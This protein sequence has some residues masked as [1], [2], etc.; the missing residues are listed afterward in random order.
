MLVEHLV[1]ALRP[2]DESDLTALP[3]NPL[4]HQVWPDGDWTIWA[5]IA[6]RGAGKTHTGAYHVHRRAAMGHSRRIALVAPTA[7][8]GRDVM[9]EGV[10]GILSIAS[11]AT[12]PKYE[13][14]KRRLTWPNGAIATLYSAEDPDQLRGPQHDLAWAEEPASWADARK[15]MVAQNT[16]WS[17]LMFG[18]RIR[19]RGSFAGPPRVIVT[20]TP[21]P[22][23]LILDIMER[24]RSERG[25]LTRGTTYDNAANLDTTFFEDLIIMYKGT[26]VGRQE[27]NAELLLDVPGALWT[28][29]MIDNTRVLLEQVPDLVTVV[30]AIDPSITAGPTSDEAGIVIAGLGV[31]GRGYVLG[32]RSAVMSPDAWGRRALGALDEY[33][34][35]YIVGEANQG[36]DMVESI[37]RLVAQQSGRTAPKVKL[38]HA[39]R[40]KQTRAQPVASLY[41]QGRISHV[42]ALSLLE[43]QLTTWTPEDGDSPDRLDALVWALTD[44]MV[45]QRSDATLI[46]W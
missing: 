31:D 6:G 18:L 21:R 30:V 46:R 7:A 35:D 12:R 13:P 9:V 11:N 39:S 22:L 29:A 4:P 19:R 41:E 5:I 32:D 10:S 14:S 43:D 26:R 16:V 38:V 15:G 2:V 42:G 44:L 17:N 20:G 34:G 24:A 3:W 37:V 8:D 45:V 28:L 27:L 33:A 25:V 1:Q 40:G 23:K 36:G